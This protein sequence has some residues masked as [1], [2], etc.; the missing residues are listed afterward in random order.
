MIGPVD[1][2]KCRPVLQSFADPAH[3]IELRQPVAAHEP[4]EDQPYRWDP[5]LGVHQNGVAAAEGPERVF[6]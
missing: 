2:V 5:D 4:Q 1:D 3:S 6:P